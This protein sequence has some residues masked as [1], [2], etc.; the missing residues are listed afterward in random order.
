MPLSRQRTY[1][2]ETFF[3]S[4]VLRWNVSEAIIPT[5]TSELAP[6]PVTLTSKMAAVLPPSQS[7]VGP[8]GASSPRLL[9]LEVT[10]TQ[11]TKTL[12]TICTST[13]A[14]LVLH[15]HDEWVQSQVSPGNIART[16]LTRPDGSYLPWPQPRPLSTSVSITSAENLLILHPD[17][18]ISGTTISD[19]FL[20]LR[21]G[22]LSARVPAQ[23]ALTSAGGE[24]ALFGSMIH[25]LFQKVLALD[26]ASRH[27]DRPGAGVE[28]L[29]V[30]EAV[31]DVLHAHIEDLYGASVSDR[32]ARRVLHKVV[33]DVLGWYN[34]FMGA[35]NP[36][37]AVGVDVLERSEN[38]H[39][40]VTAVHDIEEL[41][42]SPVLGLKGKVD[43]SVQFQVDGVGK[44]IGVFE[45]KTGSSMGYASVSHT[46]QVSLYN[47]LM[48]DRYGRAVEQ[49]LLSYIRYQEALMAVREAEEKSD[50]TQDRI[51][52]SQTPASFDQGV[53]NKSIRPLRGEVV[54]L[55][56]QRNTLAAYLRLEASVDNLPPPIKGRES[57]CTKCFASD[58]CLIQHKLLENGS[59]KTVED[60][61]GIELYRQKAAH[62]NAA[63]AAYYTFWRKVLAEEEA[64]A[65]R[66]RK[67]IW[68][69]KGAKREAH[70]RCLANLF[71]VSKEDTS[72]G[73]STELL[74]PGDRLSVTFR[75]HAGGMLQGDF[76]T[77]GISKR[78]YVVI[79]A[80]SIISED[81][82]RGRPTATE[83]WQCAL[84]NGFVEDVTATLISVT[85]DRSL[86][87]WARHQGVAVDN[88]Q[89]RVDAEEIY[90][91]H[92]TAKRTLEMLF[93]CNDT[94]DTERLRCLVVDGNAPSF[95]TLPADG[96]KTTAD[97]S[98]RF[99]LCLN[100]NQR[101]ALELSLRA[102]DYVL[103]LG[104][105]GTGKTTT[106]A[107][108]VIA[109][110]MQGKSVLL[111]SHTNAAVDN[112]LC[113]LLEVGFTDFVRL[114]RSTS[115]IDSR[116]H[117][118][119]I[120]KKFVAGKTLEEVEKS[121]NEPRVIA[122]TCLGINQPLL[123]RRG[124][125]D[126]VVVD[127]ASQILQPICIGP[128]HFADGP[129]ILVGDH[130]QLPPLLRAKPGDRLSP[131]KRTRDEVMKLQFKDESKAVRQ[132]KPTSTTESLF[133]RLCEMH[134]DAMVSLSKQ[135]RMAAEIMG[136]SN[137]LVY[138]GS[139]SCG[140]AAV[141][142]Q[143]LKVS[144]D[145]LRSLSPWLK[146]VRNPSR[147]LVF[148]NSDPKE[149]DNASTGGEKQIR[150]N[151]EHRS[152]E[153]SRDSSHEAKIVLAALRT[154]VEGGLRPEDITVLSPFRAQ[155]HLLKDEITG[156]SDC[157]GPSLEGI[158]VFTVDQYQG[159][160][161]KCVIVSFVRSHSM[162]VGPLLK[163][164]RRMNVA[165]TRAKQKLVLIGSVKTLS[166]GGH[167]LRQM[168]EYLQTRRLI[169]P[170]S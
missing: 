40:V 43:A 64:Y 11:T 99:G 38:R 113:K 96:M 90:S 151:M 120:S 36:D 80:E 12:R 119:H 170:V 72:H 55:I 156:A 139:L 77:A 85:V 161:N 160:D 138:S 111:C 35:G 75:R 27:E 153:S 121:L 164:W 2:F 45:L 31:E 87:A 82:S 79:S 91:S 70:G 51:G 126:L 15:L 52:L 19:S 53:K 142:G 69:M 29:E 37:S 133:R 94:A 4:A 56:M 145:G 123:A 22:V 155:V 20:C 117:S 73:N 44:G 7:S 166:K 150:S 1:R 105:P 84:T 167:F 115:V 14:E 10:S 100:E 21:K 25:M 48:S 46:A 122:T 141:A 107:A 68:S 54:G 124:K 39:V 42:W 76:L 118:F 163:D 129:F 34:D 128:L 114:G 152:S 26:S 16:I 159:K 106:L 103:I 140:S 17:T 33:P 88:I 9:V 143:T 157:P 32:H 41:I 74:P 92:N 168:V 169:F 49:G 47:L 97:V 63:H 158:E 5:P 86:S 8:V 148:L 132:G 58:S 130:Y 93:A 67:E 71:L 6:S 28:L 131:S 146:A 30:F 3:A 61:P 104:M 154:L 144:I 57:L 60:G 81:S 116:L 136:L 135:Y 108:V 83:T 112:L 101:Q 95:D 66:F 65:G 110:A 89:W 13:K 165:F 24:A 125:F 147:R 62:L 50:G 134:P 102:K 162:P 23:A 149:I 59:P 78:D 137:E 98:K 109:N 18:L 127:E